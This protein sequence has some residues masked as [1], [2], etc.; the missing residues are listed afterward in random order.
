[1]IAPEVPPTIA[2]AASAPPVV[3]RAEAG[4]P[5]Y[6]ERSHTWDREGWQPEEQAGA[7]PSSRALGGPFPRGVWGG[8][9]GNS[10]ILT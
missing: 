7:G 4:A 2:P 1:M 6:N 10:F 8:T 5:V 3:P 9:C